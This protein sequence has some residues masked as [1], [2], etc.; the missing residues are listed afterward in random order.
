M[1]EI[2]RVPPVDP[3]EKVGPKPKEALTRKITKKEKSPEP[4]PPAEDL[5][6]ISDEARRL[7]ELEKNRKE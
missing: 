3:T 7:K 1:S 5:L 4:E 6:E 2:K